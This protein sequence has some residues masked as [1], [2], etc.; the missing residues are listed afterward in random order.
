[1]ATK[2]FTIV[3]PV[4]NGGAQV[5]KAVQ[6]VLAQTL[7]D[8]DFLILENASTDG[9]A[10]WLEGLHD[11]RIQV[12]P[13]STL[14]PI[15]ENWRRIAQTP[16][17]EFMT[18]LGHDDA[19]DADFLETVARL[20]ARFPDATLYH[21]HFRLIDERGR[22]LR[23][24]LPVPERE[25]AAEFFLA[26]MENRRDSFGTGYVMRSADYDAVGGIPIFPKLLF[27]DD[28]L[29]LAL[30]GRGYKATAAEECFSYRLHP[31]SVSG[32]S[33]REE[34]LGGLE[35]YLH[36]LAEY[37]MADPA[38]AA[39]LDRHG[40]VMLTEALRYV[41]AGVLHEDCRRPAAAQ[42]SQATRQRIAAL[43]QTVLPGLPPF[44]PAGLVVQVLEYVR[45]LPWPI[46]RAFYPFWSCLQR[47]RQGFAAQ[48][49]RG[50][51]IPPT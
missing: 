19:F 23:H 1:M 29:W 12:V 7:D 41:Y 6:S 33:S 28:A 36:F 24:C 32:H 4:H 26:R 13:A 20:I 11:P 10:E 2:R 46:R 15:E 47:V 25:T 5:R 30:A 48:R 49:I 34:L 42:R 3:L 21:T 45:T 14:L 9:T 22:C 18:I 40:A 27:A 44:A 38:L 43:Y 50:R 16:R 51:L 35:A 8:F 37:R 39:V 17:G 31:A